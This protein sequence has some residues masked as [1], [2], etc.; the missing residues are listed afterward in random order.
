MAGR[1]QVDRNR[2]SG[3]RVGSASLTGCGWA[4]RWGGWVGDERVECGTWGI[5]VVMWLSCTVSHMSCS[6][7]TCLA[8][9][10]R[11]F[12]AC[13]AP[14]SRLS[15]GVS[16]VSHGPLHMFRGC[17]ALFHG[18]FASVAQA[19]TRVSRLFRSVSHVFRTFHSD[20]RVLLRLFHGCFTLS[21]T[22]SQMIHTVN[23][24]DILVN[25]RSLHLRTRQYKRMS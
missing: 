14:V 16:Q 10:S 1:A 23:P 21:R 22:V 11:L 6:C 17:F 18:C 8:P 20:S 2:R 13:F 25:L 9:V 15:R 12:R 5:M 19:I 24:C 7:L 3:L 4:L